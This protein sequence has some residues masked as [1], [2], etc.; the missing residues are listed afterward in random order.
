M[1]KEHQEAI[2][3]FD[4]ASTE[5]KDKEIKALAIATL[6]RLRQHLDIAITFQEKYNKK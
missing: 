5:S 2:I 1:V 3:L 6:P 4:K